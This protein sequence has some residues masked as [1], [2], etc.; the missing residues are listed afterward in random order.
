MAK[1]TIASIRLH[2]DDGRGAGHA[3]DNR[4]AGRPLRRFARALRGLLPPGTG[5][6]CPFD[7]LSLEERVRFRLGEHPSQ[8]HR[9]RSACACPVA[10]RITY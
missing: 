7:R 8:R 9:A 5:R 2:R 3:V 1:G 6:G 4:G 10:T